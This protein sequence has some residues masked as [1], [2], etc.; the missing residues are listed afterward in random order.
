MYMYDVLVA[1]HFYFE[2][3]IKNTLHNPGRDII[4]SNGLKKKQFKLWQY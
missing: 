1:L 4:H 2:F 3:C